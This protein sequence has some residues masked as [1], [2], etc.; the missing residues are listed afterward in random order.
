MVALGQCSS[1]ST[2]SASARYI[3]SSARLRVRAGVKERHRAVEVLQGPR[4]IAAAA[5]NDARP[6]Q[7]RV[8]PAVFAS[9]LDCPQR[10]VPNVSAADHDPAARP[11]CT[12]TSDPIHRVCSSSGS[13]E[14]PVI[15]SSAGLFMIVAVVVRMVSG[16]RSA[17]TGRVG[18][19][20]T[21]GLAVVAAAS[22]VLAQLDEGIGHSHPQLHR[23]GRVVGGPVGQESPRVWPR[24][25]SLT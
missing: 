10:A 18:R 16:G 11:G 1:P 4:G 2:A 25:G 8:L 5:L 9:A 17:L 13:I 7:G 15:G 19:H 20:S 3:C 12:G 24:P 22:L 14:L 23:E 6:F 21:A